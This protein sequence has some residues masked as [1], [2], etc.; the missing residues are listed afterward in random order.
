[1]SEASH[2]ISNIRLTHIAIVQLILLPLF[3]NH[4]PNR[5]V[6]NAEVPRRPTFHAQGKIMSPKIY[7]LGLLLSLALGLGASASLA[8]AEAPR[9]PTLIE[10][11]IADVAVGWETADGTPFR[12]HFLDFPGARYVESGGQNSS[13]QDL[14]ENHVEP[15]GDA[16][17]ELTLDFSDIEVNFENGFAWAVASVRV[18]ATIKSDGRKIDKKGYETFLFRDVEGTWRVVH[19]HSS[20]RS[21]K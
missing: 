8:A 12:K 9:D 3:V 2:H 13:L 7:F 17:A 16:L 21:V 1:M 4:A 15:E 18:K 14:I 10:A 6:L 11:I 5:L 20:T 19:T